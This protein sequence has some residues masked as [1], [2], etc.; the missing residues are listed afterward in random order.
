MKKLIVGSWILLVTITVASAYLLASA[1]AVDNWLLPAHGAAV[2]LIYL[3][4][5]WKALG[6]LRRIEERTEANTGPVLARQLCV[7]L[8]MNYLVVNALLA[9]LIGALKRA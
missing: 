1:V 4:L 9:L 8:L 3:F 5:Q 2:M 7:G 6:Q